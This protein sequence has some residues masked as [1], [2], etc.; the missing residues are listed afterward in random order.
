MFQPN[1]SYPAREQWELVTSW[2][3]LTKCWT[4]ISVEVGKEK[5]F[6]KSEFGTGSVSAWPLYRF[7]GQSNQCLALSQFTFVISTKCDA[8]QSSES[9][10]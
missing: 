7:F 5:C 3:I 6:G 8:K 1:V 2:N 9:N 4:K 10:V